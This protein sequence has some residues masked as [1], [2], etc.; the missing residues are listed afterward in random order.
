MEASW[1][2]LKLKFLGIDRKYKRKLLTHINAE[3]VMR[4]FIVVNVDPC[5]KAS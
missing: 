4:T 2:I 5:I 1:E 3:K